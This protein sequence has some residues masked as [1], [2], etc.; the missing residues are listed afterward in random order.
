MKKTRKRILDL[1]GGVVITPLQKVIFAGT[2]A[3]TP[4]TLKK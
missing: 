1:T 3:I 2:T 4:I